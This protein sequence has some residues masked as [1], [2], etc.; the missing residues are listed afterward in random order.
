MSADNG[1][2]IGKWNDG[3]RVCHAQAIENIDCVDIG[4][5]YECLLFGKSK[6][7]STQKEASEQ[8]SKI[9]NEIM[10]SDFPICE[11]GICYVGDRGEWANIDAT[12]AYKIIMTAFDQD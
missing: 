11:Y 1:V 2:Y 12:E 3:Y 9:Y 6:I 7:F 8:A 4:K 10:E 5:E